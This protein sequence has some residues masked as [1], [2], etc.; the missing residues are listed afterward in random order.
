M[1]RMTPGARQGETIS[2]FNHA[3]DDPFGRWLTHNM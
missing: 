3:S 2:T 1:Y